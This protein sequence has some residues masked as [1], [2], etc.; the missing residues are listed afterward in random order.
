MKLTSRMLTLEKLEEMSSLVR[1]QASPLCTVNL[2]LVMKGVIRM[3]RVRVM[4]YLNLGSG[5][6]MDASSLFMMKSKSGDI[7]DKVC[8]LW[9]LNL[10]WVFQ[11]LRKTIFLQ[12]QLCDISQNWFCIS[13]QFA[14]FLSAA[15]WVLYSTL[16]FY[17]KLREFYQPA[18][19]D[20]TKCQLR[21]QACIRRW[22]CATALIFWSAPWG[23]ISHFCL[24]AGALWK[25]KI[26]HKFSQKG[27]QL[28]MK[29]GHLETWVL[30]TLHHI[31]MVV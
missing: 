18:L 12:I 6:C 31:E 29:Q 28:L 15:S 13:F 7:V 5:V 4:L 11:S 9:L 3:L 27:I 25:L 26:S 14:F 16:Y 17:V 19:W 23:P 21:C 24:P 20:K 2:S 30:G 8:P 1:T 10:D 22:S